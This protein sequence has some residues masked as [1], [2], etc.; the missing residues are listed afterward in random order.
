[1]KARFLFLVLEII[2]AIGIAVNIILCIL[3]SFPFNIVF[4]IL[5]IEYFLFFILSAI[6]YEKYKLTNKK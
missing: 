3:L 6:H 4:I 2:F 1:M 5:T